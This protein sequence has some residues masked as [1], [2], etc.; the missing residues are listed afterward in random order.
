MPSRDVHPPDAMMHSLCFK[1]P[2]FPKKVLDSVENVS[3]F[4]FSQKISRFSSAKMFFSHLPQFFLFPTIF[5]V[6]IHFP[7]FQEILLFPS[8][9]SKFPPIYVKFTM[10][11][12]YFKCFS[13]P[14]YFDHDAF[15]HRTMHVADSHGAIYR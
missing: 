2:L 15:M 8:Y 14:P 11:F 4:T 5:A 10:L 7:L 1:F 9:F 12:I 3:N 6:S 13:F